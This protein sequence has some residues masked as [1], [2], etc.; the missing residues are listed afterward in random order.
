MQTDDHSADQVLSHEELATALGKAAHDLNNLCAS[1]LGFTAL[2][3]ESLAA[4]SPVQEFLGE[5]LAA[6][7]KTAAL[8]EQ[9]RS[10]ARA[11]RR[12]AA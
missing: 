8:A 9:L 3:Q 2:T 10:L 4:D 5:V 12:T 6:A 7:D 11:A 1:I